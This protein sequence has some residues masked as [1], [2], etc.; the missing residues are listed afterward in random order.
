MHFLGKT[1]KNVAIHWTI[2]C[3]NRNVAEE[4]QDKM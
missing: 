3:V 2:L 1:E 4:S